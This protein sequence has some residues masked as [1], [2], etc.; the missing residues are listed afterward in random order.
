[1]EFF[2]AESSS[3]AAMLKKLTTCLG[4]AV[5]AAGGKLTSMN[6]GKVLWDVPGY[7][8]WKGDKTLKDVLAELGGFVPPDI[9]SLY[10]VSQ[11]TAV[12]VKAVIPPH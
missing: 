10:E 3:S 6:A 2:T 4:Q 1:M 11:R 7:M 12:A 8:S 5:D 9:R